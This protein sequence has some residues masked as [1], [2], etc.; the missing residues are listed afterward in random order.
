VQ[1]T[2]IKLNN[3][4]E[5]SYMYGGKKHFVYS[6]SA[7]SLAAVKRFGSER[8]TIK[9]YKIVLKSIKI[10]I[11][12]FPHMKLYIYPTLVPSWLKSHGEHNLESTVHEEF[13]IV[14]YYMTNCPTD[15]K[16]NACNRGL[17]WKLP[18]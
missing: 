18:L 2:A 10:L 17:H 13:K 6:L 8:S 11:N 7:Q 12:C 16:N 14:L 1:S 15:Y 5:K 3:R 9:Y 4:E